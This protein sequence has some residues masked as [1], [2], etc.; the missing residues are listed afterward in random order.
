M[1]VA[2]IHGRVYADDPANLNGWRILDD[3]AV[4]MEGGAIYQ[5][6]HTA[7]LLSGLSSV[8]T[9]VDVEGRA[10][11]PGFIDCHTHVPFA[12]WRLD[13]YLARLSGTSYEALTR[14]KGGIV[15]SSRQWAAASDS[16]IMAMARGLVAEAM[17][18]GTTAMEMK[19]GY[20]LTVDQELRALR[21]IKQL[22]NTL[23]L[24]VVATGLFLH[25]VP[26]DSEPDQWVDA[27]VSD[28]L[29]M[30]IHE[31]LLDA[32]DAFVETTAFTPDQVQ[33][34]LQAVP[35]PIIRRLHTNQ[36]SSIGGMAAAATVGARAVDHLEHLTPQE[37]DLMVQYGM[38]GVVMPTA[39]FY[40]NRHHYA[41][42]RELINRGVRVALA[43]DLNPG[44]SPVGNLPTV[45]A[46]AVNLCDM[47]PEEALAAVTRHAAYV[48]GREEQIGSLAVGQRANVVVLDA[49]SVGMIPYRLG[50]NPVYRVWIGGRELMAG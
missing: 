28:L 10:I 13:E 7:R 16:A 48:L 45:M 1:G 8:D 18:W 24:D 46:I 12:A 39:S 37:I 19:S 3:G 15:R 14:E 38:A 2:L 26:P 40:A 34:F 33:R 27:V 17:R 42:V 31:G 47:T 21:L 4:F 35:L 50:H 23:P 25:A 22:A 32:V 44:T 6:D 49:E 41:P 43:T 20:G 5:V 36:F 29:P 11:V 30:A 9:V